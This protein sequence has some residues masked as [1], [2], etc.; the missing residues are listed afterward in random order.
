MRSAPQA[1]DPVAED[2]RLLALHAYGVLDTS[3]EPGLDDLVRLIAETCGTPVAAIA[4]VDRSRVWVK[5]SVGLDARELARDGCWDVAVCSSD[6]LVVP[7]T[8]TARGPAHGIHVTGRE[9]R[10]FAAAPLRTPDGLDLG[11]L[12]VL[13]FQPRA[14][15]PAQ[16]FALQTLARQVMAQLELARRVLEADTRRDELAGV[17]QRLLRLI[18]TMQ[19]AT[20]VQDEH[21]HVALA[22]DAVRRLFRLD[23]PVEMLIGLDASIHEEA[24]PLFDDPAAFVRGVRE[25]LASRSERLGER[26][27]MR[28]GRTVERDSVPIMVGESHRG[29]LWQYR[30]ITD[31]LRAEA[32]LAAGEARWRAVV[33]HMLEGL[34]LVRDA[35]GVIRAINPAAA[36]ILGY[37]P[38]EIVGQHIRELMPDDPE[39]RSAA[40]FIEAYKAAIGRTT[41]WRIR[42][43]DGTVVPV[44]LQLFEF[45]SAEGRV[46]AGALRDMS[47]RHEIEKLKKQFVS[48]VSHELRTPLTSISGSLALL[49]SGVVGDL[50]AQGQD[51][52]QVA[53]RSIARLMALVND[54][55]D[56]GRLEAGRMEVRPVPVHAAE[57]VE[58]ALETVRPLATQ[59]HVAIE[60]RPGPSLQVLADRNRIVQVLVNLLSNA[61]KFSPPGAPITV[62]WTAEAGH[63]RFIVE[64]R[65]RGVPMALQQVI[66]EPFRQVEREDAQAKGGSG[67]GLAI[68]RALVEQHHGA[69]GVTSREGRGATFWF[70]LPQPNE[71]A[72]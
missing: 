59:A 50:P 68:A 51:L 71:G 17:S 41:E 1:A 70:T 30:D 45:D 7:D 35:D 19:A 37:Q 10:F 57:L 36:R 40:F 13:D 67:L 60:V 3:P 63:A 39:S 16:A 22:N 44:E 28:D 64:D 5:A 47:D 20:V 21:G 18:Q 15:L 6:V 4:F 61:V 48:M 34:V 29:H 12:A 53:Q 54:L 42:R 11:V 24:A 38:D 72:A 52:L 65:G 56:L 58:Q 9:V 33:D 46:L 55:L 23:V 8:R 49:Q 2:A 43:K 31:R 69:I 32:D 26:L 66:F 62:A 25:C 27:R 14:L